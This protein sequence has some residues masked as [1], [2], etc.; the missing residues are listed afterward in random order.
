[1]CPSAASTPRT[2]KSAA[3]LDV[4]RSR[5]TDGTWP[6]G[7]RIPGEHDLATELGVGRNTLREA[8]RSLTNQGLLTARAGDG[9]YVIATDELAAALARRVSPEESRQALEVRGALEMQAARIA[10]HRIS[11]TDLDT[12]RGLTRARSEASAKADD[13]AFVRADLAWHEFI[14]AC[15]ENPLLT[16]L[17]G[18]LDRAASYTRESGESDVPRLHRPAQ[19][20]DLAHHEVLGALIAREPDAAMRAAAH[21]TDIAATHLLEANS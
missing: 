18:G 5:L 17:Y 21:L 9:T 4:L 10:A 13:A 3:T 2:S 19:A 1:M 6:V 11:D 15:C 20:M 12:L 14:V 7:T 8:L 16:D